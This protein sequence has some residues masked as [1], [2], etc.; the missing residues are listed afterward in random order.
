M[1]RR[2]YMKESGMI[3]YAS[4]AAVASQTRHSL[5]YA[6]FKASRYPL[7]SSFALINK[8]MIIYGTSL[9]NLF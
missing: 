6:A 7:S 4:C 3:L 8:E 2:R 1:G 5:H 9:P